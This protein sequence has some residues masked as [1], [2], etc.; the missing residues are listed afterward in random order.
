MFNIFKKS[1]D[2]AF[3][4]FALKKDKQLKKFIQN[5]Y[6]TLANKPPKRL[7]QFQT[8]SPYKL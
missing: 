1:W 5:D 7:K 8:Q 3:D 4:V 6:E 2:S